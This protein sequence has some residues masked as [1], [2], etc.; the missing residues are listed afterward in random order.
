[1]AKSKKRE[2]PEVKQPGA[3]RQTV[4]RVMLALLRGNMWDNEVAS[5]AGVSTRTVYRTVKDAQAAGFT[6]WKD[7][8]GKFHATYE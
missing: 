4:L 1:M 6:V 5:E 7:A 2:I 8:D 3:N